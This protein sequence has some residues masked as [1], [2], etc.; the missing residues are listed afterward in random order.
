MIKQYVNIHLND[1]TDIIN[2]EVPQSFINEGAIAYWV[3]D[4][5]VRMIPL[6]HVKHIDML[7]VPKT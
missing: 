4:E 1:G 7:G 2:V 6:R 5:I 3:S